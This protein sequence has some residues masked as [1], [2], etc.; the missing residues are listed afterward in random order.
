ML[1]LS[2]LPRLI[3]K[4]SLPDELRTEVTTNVSAMLNDLNQMDVYDD[5]V[6]QMVLVGLYRHLTQLTERL[7]DGGW[8]SED[9]DLGYRFQEIVEQLEGVLYRGD[10]RE[11]RR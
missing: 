10:L 4:S 2:E 1:G 9:K 6:A 11:F 5:P 3:T 7:R 8:L